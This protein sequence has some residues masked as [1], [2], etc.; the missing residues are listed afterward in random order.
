MSIEQDIEA[1]KR[2]EFGAN[3]AR[4][5]DVLD[6]ARILDAEASIKEMLGI[7]SLEG[8][9]FLDIGCGSGLFSLAARR[10]GATVHSFDFDPESVSC[11]E[12]LKRRYFP[13]DADWQIERG[14]A[15]DYRYMEELGQFDVVY[16]WGVLHHTGAM[17]LALEYAIRRVE[18][19]HGRLYIAIYNEQSWKSRLWWFVKC[20]YNRLPR[21]LRTPFVTTIVGLTHAANIVR[22][23]VKLRPMA[24]IGPLL[25][26]SSERGMSVRRDWVDWIGGFPYEFAS[27]ETLEAYLQVRGFTLVSAK[28][29]SSWGCNELALQRGG[30]AA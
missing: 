15:L 13:S 1:G 25:H 24:A 19:S 27:F 4:F 7:T 5:L 3:W 26:Y 28:R 21:F 23:T 9:S 2:F 18:D 30:C 12:E 17:W 29:T 8:R 16:S 6:E 10:L 14:S 22:Q 11:A 20:F